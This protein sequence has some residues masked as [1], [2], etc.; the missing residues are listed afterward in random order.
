MMSKFDKYS[1]DCKIEVAGEELDL[2]VR[3]KDVK[4]IMST[5]KKHGEISEKGVEKMLDG[6]KEIVM[7]SYPDEDEKNIES[8]LTK[9]FV[10]FLQEF[11]DE[12]GWADKSEMKKKAESLKKKV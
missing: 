9:N 5:Q 7:R 10:E 4:N 2:D 12:M 6:F 3:L 11:S 8:F 1:G